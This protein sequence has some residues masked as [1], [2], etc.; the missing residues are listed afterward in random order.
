MFVDD[1]LY[2]P[3]FG[4]S[5]IFFYSSMKRTQTHSYRIEDDRM[6]NMRPEMELKGMTIG[7]QLYNLISTQSIRQSVKSNKRSNDFYFQLKTFNQTISD[8]H[9]I[10]TPT[11]I[12]SNPHF[13]QN[14][15]FFQIENQYVYT[16]FQ[17][18]IFCSMFT[19]FHLCFRKAFRTIHC[20]LNILHIGN[21]QYRF[22]NIWQYYYVMRNICGS[23]L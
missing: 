16:Y 14:T 13:S 7:Q 17:F 6:L 23:S 10:E 1:L 12:L 19:S 21:V 4:A 2:L 20:Y 22:S 18:R 9:S 5:L 8:S 15:I 3:L 11:S